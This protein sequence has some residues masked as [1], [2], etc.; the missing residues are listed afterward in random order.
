MKKP[1]RHFQ[2]K[3]TDPG[4]LLVNSSPRRV[5]NAA[6]LPLPRC[7]AAEA[8]VDSDGC[9]ATT[10]A[11]GAIGIFAVSVHEQYPA[12]ERQRIR[13]LEEVG[14]CLSSRVPPGSDSLWVYPGGYFGFDPLAFREGGG[15]PWPGFDASGIREALP[16]VLRSYPAGA[17]LALGAD[18][19]EQQVWV[20]WLG[21]GG[22]F[23]LKTI[24]RHHCDLPE[25][26]VKVA[27]LRAAFFVCGE[28]T[29]S[30]T[31]ANGPFCGDQYLADPATQLADC[32]LLVDLAHSRVKGSVYGAPG[33]RLVH[34]R[35]ML[36]FTSRRGTAILTHH[37]PGCLTAGRAR[38]DCQSN[39][40]IF[41]G[42][43]RL[44][45]SRVHAVPQSR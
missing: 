8:W 31:K 26:S 42:C 36:R 44:D 17:K 10:Q 41:H 15:E 25:R 28:F 9:E 24:T 27:S 40:V 32:H 18:G 22:S 3:R 23:Q 5:E 33:P 13:L 16:T 39:W 19:K 38:D 29:G 34:Q 30:Y 7:W 21:A 4:S 45:E 14:Q 2:D 37:H 20:S 43:K 6:R 11:P 1:T 35:Q 12:E